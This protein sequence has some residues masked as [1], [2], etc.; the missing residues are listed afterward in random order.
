MLHSFQSHSDPPAPE[1]PRTR[2]RPAAYD[3]EPRGFDLGGRVLDHLRRTDLTPPAP[4]VFGHDQQI[5]SWM[6]LAAYCLRPVMRNRANP[7]RAPPLSVLV[8]PRP[9][10]E[11]RPRAAGAGKMAGTNWWTSRAGSARL[12]RDGE[13]EGASTGE[14]CTRSTL[15]HR[16]P[17]GRLQ[18]LPCGPLSMAP[19]SQR[20]TTWRSLAKRPAGSELAEPKSRVPQSHHFSAVTKEP[21]ITCGGFLH[22][23]PRAGSDESLHVGH[24]DRDSRPHGG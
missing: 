4:A 17:S 20:A 19:D 6:Y 10:A 15:G 7:P 5:G 14:G 23:A 12:L 13:A 21:P 2:K 18:P 11:L 3:S 8:R 1:N 9:A 16:C 22:V 24:R